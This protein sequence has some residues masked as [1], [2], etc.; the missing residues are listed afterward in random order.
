[1]SMIIDGYKCHGEKE[2]GELRRVGDE[3]GWRRLQ[4]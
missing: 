3:C 1:M 2:R 4:F